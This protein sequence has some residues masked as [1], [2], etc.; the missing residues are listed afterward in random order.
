[1]FGSY[2]FPGNFYAQNTI[3]FIAIYVKPGKP[4]NGRTQ[5]VKNQSRL[6]QK[7]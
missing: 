3:E 4:H 1:M 2:P 5:I 7:E 6:S